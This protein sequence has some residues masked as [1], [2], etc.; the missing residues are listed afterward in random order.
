MFLLIDELDI[1]S[2]AEVSTPYITGHTPYVMNRLEN[3]CKKF[4]EWF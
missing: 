4:F 2:Y 1:A 3:A